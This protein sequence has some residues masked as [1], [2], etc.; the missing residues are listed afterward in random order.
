MREGGAIWERW[1]LEVEL[2]GPARRSIGDDAVRVEVEVE[3]DAEARGGGA[4]GVGAETAWTSW[5]RVETYYD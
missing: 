1:L 2:G 4:V 5:R 3:M